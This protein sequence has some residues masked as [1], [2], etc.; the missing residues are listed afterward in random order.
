M[1]A[2]V[3]RQHFVGISR[4][5]ASGSHCVSD[6]DYFLL[7]VLKTKGVSKIQR[8]FPA[9]SAEFADRQEKT[10]FDRGRVVL[11]TSVE[12]L[13]RVL[14]FLFGLVVLSLGIA[15]VTHAGLG[16]G[17]VSSAAIVLSRQTGLSMGLFVF[18]T[19]VF[20]FVLQCLVD[21]KNLLIKA[22]KQLPVCAFFG[23]VFDVAM[24]LTSFM[25]PTNY[26]WAFMQVFLG[27]CL[28]GL[29]VSAMVF[30]RLLV[31][32]P[33]GFVIAVMHRFGGSFGTIRTTVDVFLVT[34]SV[35]MSLFF[36]GTVYGVREGTLISALFAGR[37]ANGFL[38]RWGRL[39]PQHRPID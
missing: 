4:F 1:Q 25:D 6:I 39:F 19:N 14:I 27:T 24:W 18:L 13:S 22:V 23:A 21:P 10:I 29:G 36:F 38:R 12:M 3:T 9:R 16:T 11:F 37:M 5:P 35:M 30:A 34:V 33:E 15:T 7:L 20:F 2:H 17:T 31:L 32:P 8:L 26:G 28:T